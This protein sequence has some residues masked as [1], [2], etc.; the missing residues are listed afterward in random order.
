[1]QAAQLVKYDRT[2][3]GVDACIQCL[4]DEECNV[5]SERFALHAALH[6]PRVLQGAR[7]LAGRRHATSE[8]ENMRER[9]HVLLEI[10]EIYSSAVR[11][12][13]NRRGA[14]RGAAA[15]TLPVRHRGLGIFFIGKFFQGGERMRA[16]AMHRGREMTVAG[17]HLGL[18]DHSPVP[19]LPP[20]PAF[21][22]LVKRCAR[23]MG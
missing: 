5:V 16:A 14:R 20:P 10:V 6:P 8:C 4:I 15:A 3:G 23:K 9:W 12:Q 17:A 11:S 18:A 22:A 13:P 21:V 1:M 19:R 2:I 7:E